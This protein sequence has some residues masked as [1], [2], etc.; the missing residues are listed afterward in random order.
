MP[1]T[2]V[3]EIL[4]A[5]LITLCTCLMLC[6]EAL[7]LTARSFCCIHSKALHNFWQLL[8]VHNRS[9]CIGTDVNSSDRIRV[10]DTNMRYAVP[11]QTHCLDFTSSSENQCRINTTPPQSQPTPM[12]E[13]ET[14]PV[15]SQSVPAALLKALATSPHI[16]D[17]TVH[18]IGCIATRE[19][20]QHHHTF[21]TPPYMAWV[22]SSHRECSNTTTHPIHHC[23]WL[24]LHLHTGNAPTPPH[25]QTTTWH[26]LH[27]HTGSAA[28]NDTWNEKEAATAPLFRTQSAPL[29][30]H[31]SHKMA[32]ASPSRAELQEFE[33]LLEG[34]NVHMPTHLQVASGTSSR[35]EL[36]GC[37]ELCLC[38][39][40]V[41]TLCLCQKGFCVSR[42]L[43]QGTLSTCSRT[44]SGIRHFA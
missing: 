12:L 7:L 31:S 28:S 13:P 25:T 3:A 32:P 24:R 23:T 39:K 10:T 29:R 4:H 38:P 37:A 22:A 33:Q 5:D 41:H 14:T 16:Q 21:N 18:G 34:T 15:P 6:V 20:Q 40:V 26:R 1:S 19:V 44:A 2:A 9:I 27:N 11:Y 30:H 17:T 43:L 8:S 36:K 35:Y 42:H